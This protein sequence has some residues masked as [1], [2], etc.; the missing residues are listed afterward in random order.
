MYFPID[1]FH[2]DWKEYKAYREGLIERGFQ[3]R[4]S[5]K[6]D[7]KPHHERHKEAQHAQ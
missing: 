4:T 3:N 6:A 1:S 7:N 5:R 2:S